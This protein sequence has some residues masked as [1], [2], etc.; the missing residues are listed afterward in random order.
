MGGNNE[1]RLESYA[2]D[3]LKQ[4]GYQYSFGQ[5]LQGRSFS[6]V[7]LLKD[8]KKF[9]SNPYIEQEVI[10]KL[11]NLPYDV[12]SANAVVWEYIQHGIWIDS[13][14]QRIPLIDFHNPENNCFKVI[15]QLSINTGSNTRRPDVI[16][17]INGLPL[18]IF[19][20]KTPKKRSYILHQ[21]YSQLTHTYLRDIPNIFKYAL[22]LVISNGYSHRY[23]TI[24]NE[25]K[26]W[27]IW[28]NR[29][30]NHFLWELFDKQILLD[31]IKNF[32]YITNQ[33]H[34]NLISGKTYQSINSIINQILNNSNKEKIPIKKVNPNYESITLL[35]KLTNTKQLKNY[36]IIWF[37]DENDNWLNNL[38]SISTKYLNTYPIIAKEVLKNFNTNQIYLTNIQDY[39]VSPTLITNSNNLICISHKKYPSIKHNSWIIWKIK[40]LLKF[41]NTNKVTYYNPHYRTFLDYLHYSFPNAI[42]LVEQSHKNY[43]KVLKIL[44]TILKG[45]GYLLLFIL[46]MAAASG[47]KGNYRR[48]STRYRKRW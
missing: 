36:S 4:K 42:H 6:E 29:Y 46:I 38:L 20:L 35:K 39:F 14:K 30:L 7:L 47:A 11:K 2:I 41:K 25:I 27:H 24:H 9:L 44:L 17:Y 26:H 28:N 22:F 1:F 40:A 18:I 48:R 5:F 16:I 23:G 34:T 10:Y 15:N 33:N 19:E 32:I 13:I 37:I 12:S 8:L 21:A 43:S 31:Y 45:F 3:V